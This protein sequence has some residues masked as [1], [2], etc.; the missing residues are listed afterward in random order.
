[1][2]LLISLLLFSYNSIEIFKKRINYAAEDINRIIKGDFYG[3]FGQ[4]AGLIYVGI[5]VF[6]E[7]PLLGWG[8][9]DNFEAIKTIVV[10]EDYKKFKHVYNVMN[11]HF[12]NQYII[13][14]TQLGIVGLVLFLLIF[15]YLSRIKIA[16]TEITRIRFLF[17]VV[18]MV[19]LVS[20]EFFHQLH[21]IGLFALFSGLFLSQ[22]KY[23]NS[24]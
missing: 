4:R 11:Q 17:I 19:S 7:K 24:Q 5:E 1:M 13:Y 15:Y 22:N 16:N 2:I 8:V 14:A 10:R 3:S 18:F 20:T 9:K 12:H 6:K 23:E 21:P